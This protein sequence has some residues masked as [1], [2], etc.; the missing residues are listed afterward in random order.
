MLC[1]EVMALA[2]S[3]KELGGTSSH[4]IKPSEGWWN[5]IAKDDGFLVKKILLVRQAISFRREDLRPF[6]RTPMEPHPPDD[7]AVLGETHWKIYQLIRDQPPGIGIT[8]PSILQ[9]LSRRHNIHMEEGTLTSNYIKPLKD[10]LGVMNRRKYGYYI[11]NH[12][13][14]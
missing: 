5:E 8:G 10:H 4:Y 2:S 12:V 1:S 13:E 9:E 7:D 14:K 3:L 11:Q 6:V